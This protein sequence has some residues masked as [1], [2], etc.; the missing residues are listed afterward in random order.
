[1]PLNPSSSLK[2]HRF[3]RVIK[4]SFP[5]TRGIDRA[6]KNRDLFP[7]PGKAAQMWNA[8]V[9]KTLTQAGYKQ[10]MYDPC[11][12]YKME[13]NEKYNPVLRPSII[14][15]MMEAVHAGAA[16]ESGASLVH[17]VQMMNKYNKLSM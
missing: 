12:F 11:L 7:W 13:D 6:R 17:G 1:M 4:L 14:E 5:I 16:I 2:I 9:T 10:S 15:E 3:H 8:L